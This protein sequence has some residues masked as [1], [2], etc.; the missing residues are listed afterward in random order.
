MLLQADASALLIVDVQARLLPAIHEG[1][2]VLQNCAWLVRLSRELNV[3]VGVTEQYPQGLGPTVAALR[4]LVAPESVVQKLHFSCVAE[5]C[6]A[7][8]PGFSR[9]QIV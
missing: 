7:Q 5:G 8:L 2:R 1:E 6:L 4:E 9:E 3:P